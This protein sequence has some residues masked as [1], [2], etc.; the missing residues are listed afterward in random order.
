MN[1][2]L[3]LIS[4]MWSSAARAMNTF[5]LLSTSYPDG[6]RN[7]YFHLAIPL[8]AVA[9]ASNALPGRADRYERFSSRVGRVPRP[10]RKVAF[11]P[12][13]LQG[14]LTLVNKLF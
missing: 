3:L 1:T 5:Q 14:L 4:A 11:P 12:T 9:F 13:P 2:L 6:E 7:E 8:F 10:V